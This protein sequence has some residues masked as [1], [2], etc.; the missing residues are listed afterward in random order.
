MLF[1]TVAAPFDISA[2]SVHGFPFLRV[3]ASTCYFLSVRF[4]GIAIPVDVPIVLLICISL[5]ISDVE[6]LLCAY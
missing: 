4:F 3:L 2:D 5:K 1:P 6:H